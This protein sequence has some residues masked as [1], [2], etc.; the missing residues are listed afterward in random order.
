[1]S[2]LDDLIGD[3][4]EWMQRAACTNEEQ[5]GIWGGL[6]LRERRALKKGAA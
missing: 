3:I 1:M 2:S 6:T 4:P 5:H